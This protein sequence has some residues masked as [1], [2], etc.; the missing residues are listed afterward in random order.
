MLEL[1]VLASGCHDHDSSPHFRQDCLHIRYMPLLHVRQSHS[2]GLLR[3]LRPIL[4]LLHHHCRFGVD[5][6]WCVL[7]EALSQRFSHAFAGIAILVTQKDNPLS[8][9]QLKDGCQNAM[10]RGFAVG[11]VLGYLTWCVCAPMNFAK[12]GAF[13]QSRAFQVLRSSPCFLVEI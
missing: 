6:C 1:A 2:Q 11:R 13:L 7:A 5:V 8:C 3:L 4:L 9:H 12:A 10:G